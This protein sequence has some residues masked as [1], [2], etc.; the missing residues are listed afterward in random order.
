MDATR[1]I[2]ITEARVNWDLCAW[3][4]AARSQGEALR[5]SLSLSLSFIRRH[6]DSNSRYFKN[7]TLKL[8]RRS[9]A[10]RAA[11]EKHL[12]GGRALVRV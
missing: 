4:C 8:G 2:L 6:E 5:L 12:D 7:E 9:A 10:P 1:Y 11:L 3:N